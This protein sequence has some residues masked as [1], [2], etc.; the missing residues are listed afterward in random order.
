MI[1]FKQKV[2]II[3]MF[4][5]I[6][7]SNLINSQ[8]LS[9]S[10]SVGNYVEIFNNDSIKIYY[11]CTG[12]NVERRCAQFFRV[13][14]ID[15]LFCNITDRF[16]DYFITGEVAFKGIMR[17]GKLNGI[18][19]YFHRNG[20]VS[21]IGI[22][23]NNIRNGE[24]RYFYSNGKLMKTFNFI[25]G[26]P[27]VINYYDK[28]GIERVRNGDGYYVGGFNG[29]K[30][31]FPFMISGKIC[32]GKRDSIWTFSGVNNEIWDKGKFIQGSTYMQDNK[33][34]PMMHLQGFVANENC[35]IVENLIGC[36]GDQLFFVYYKGENLH[37]TFYPNLERKIKRAI[38]Y[39]IDNQWIF[40]GIEID[41]NDKL[42]RI[43]VHSSIHD[44]IVESIIFDLINKS[45][46]GWKTANINH[47]KVE[48]NLL[49]P[50]VVEDHQIQIQTYH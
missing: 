45:N 24:W 25:E 19:T 1:V 18:G 17:Y 26:D 30:G 42:S 38:N 15:S 28:D 3:I 32:E 47:M 27:L 10:F 5:L 21:E 44:T 8:P 41:K 14:K 6:G 13:G 35:S 43:N 20:N 33:R 4:L 37:Y 39:K 50:I 23:S 22:Y 36:P 16:T 48:T 12:A 7:I 46:K 31:C 11:N 29:Y 40:V 49:F 9:N 2:R 34:Y